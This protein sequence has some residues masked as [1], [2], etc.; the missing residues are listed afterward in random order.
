MAEH[1]NSKGY[2]PPTVVKTG[3]CLN[4]NLCETICPDYAIFTVKVP[5]VL[6]AAALPSGGITGSLT[7]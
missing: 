3:E 4:C 5:E 6:P 1:F 2:H 7:P